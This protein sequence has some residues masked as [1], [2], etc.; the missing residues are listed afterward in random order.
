M[1]HAQ[2]KQQVC[3][4][5]QCTAEQYA[6]FQY[7]TGLAYLQL[8]LHGYQPVQYELEASKIF[9]NW[10]KNQWA[11]RDAQFLQADHRGNHWAIYLNHNDAAML[12]SEMRPNAIVLGRSWAVMIGQVIK[13]EVAA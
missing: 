4:L 1:T 13:Q 12:A 8:Y 7:E 10:W 9:W 11:M 5:L 2:I 6:V 3:Q